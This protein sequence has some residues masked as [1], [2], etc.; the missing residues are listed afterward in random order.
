MC[1]VLSC[2][3]LLKPIWLSRTQKLNGT[4]SDADHWI[5]YLKTPVLTPVNWPERKPALIHDRPLLRTLGNR[6]W[7]PL[8]GRVIGIS[9]GYPAFLI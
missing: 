1:P 5:A 9:N 7:V 6:L 2:P 4:V 3:G 8:G